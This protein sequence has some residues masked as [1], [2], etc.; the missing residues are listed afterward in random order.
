MPLLR[1][2]GSFSHEKCSTGVTPP[3]TAHWVASSILLFQLAIQ[4]GCYN[5]AYA[6]KYEDVANQSSD[7]CNLC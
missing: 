5:T 7:T 3:E 4:T 1:S 6:I 2:L